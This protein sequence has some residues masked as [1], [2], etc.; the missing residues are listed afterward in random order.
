MECLQQEWYNAWTITEYF[1]ATPY[2]IFNYILNGMIFR[3]FCNHL[4]QKIL[5]SV[6]WIHSSYFCSNILNQKPLAFVDTDVNMFTLLKAVWIQRC[7]REF[8]VFC[9]GNIITEL[10]LIILMYL[11]ACLSQAW[12]VHGSKVKCFS[13][14]F[15]CLLSHLLQ[16]FCKHSMSRPVQAVSAGLLDSCCPDLD[17]ICTAEV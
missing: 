15:V 5:W 17:H 11:M 12:Y 13:P 4:H 2:Y 16:L 9:C 3:D 7:V 8:L 1:M 10:V 14:C 6:I